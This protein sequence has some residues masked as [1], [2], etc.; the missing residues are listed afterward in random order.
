MK[1]YQK[2]IIPHVESLYDSF[3]PSEKTI[4]DFFIRNTEEVDV[5]SKNLS[6]KLFVSEA[7]ISRFAKKCGFDGYREFIFVYKQSFEKSTPNITTSYTK[8]VLNTYE[9][10]L[11]KSYTL[12]DEKQMQRIVDMIS[13][14]KRIYIYGR[15]SSG[16]VA[17]EMKLRLMRLGVNVEAI[18]DSH[19]MKMNSVLMDNECLVI[20]ISISGN[21]KEVINSLKEAHRRGS[22]IVLITSKQDEEMDKYCDEILYVA[23]KEHLENGKAISPQF[24]VL[25]IVDIFYA[26]FLQSD[27][28]RKEE[29]HSNTLH[30]LYE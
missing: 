17:Q 4:A 27:R 6:K 8:Q 20:G 26:H 5:S 21:T 22:S 23:V 24:P 2:S 19:I 12:I 16:L 25:V 15:G 29:L 28:L 7:S 18:S 9:E 10:L 11:N 14:K 1:E 3:T 30:A 13:N